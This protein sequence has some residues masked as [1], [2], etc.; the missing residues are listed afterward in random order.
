MQTYKP[1]QFHKHLVQFRYLSDVKSIV[2]D[3]FYLL[4]M[5]FNADSEFITDIEKIVE[6]IVVELSAQHGISVH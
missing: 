1:T 4:T 6:I 5:A 3:F 2:I